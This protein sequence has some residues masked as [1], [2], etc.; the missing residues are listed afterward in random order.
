M[1][2]YLIISKSMFRLLHDSVVLSNSDS[3][4]FPISIALRIFNAI[5]LNNVQTEEKTRY[6]INTENAHV[7]S[8]WISENIEKGL[9]EY[10]FNSLGDVDVNIDNIIL[11]YF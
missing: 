2:D 6:Y 7:Y 3:C 8:N 9:F 10:V 4:H 5:H 1:R 11:Y